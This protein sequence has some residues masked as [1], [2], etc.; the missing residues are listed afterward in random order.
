MPRNSQI[1]DKNSETLDYLQSMLGQLRALAVAERY[2][3]LSYLI[4]MAFL[5]ASD[6]ANGARPSATRRDQLDNV[7]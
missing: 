5:E 6:I 4:D 2:D 3:M 1:G 7:G